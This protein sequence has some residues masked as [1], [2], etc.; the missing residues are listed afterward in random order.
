MHAWQHISFH[1]HGQ[2]EITVLDDFQVIFLFY[3]KGEGSRT[4]KGLV[5]PLGSAAR[6]PAP[7]VDCRLGHDLGGV[8]FGDTLASTIS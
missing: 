7:Q 6:Q 2:R 5:V 8:L 1:P 3:N 4:L